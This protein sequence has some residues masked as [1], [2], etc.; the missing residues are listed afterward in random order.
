MSRLFEATVRLAYTQKHLQPFLLPLLAREER[1]RAKKA[2]RTPRW[3]SDMLEMTA[4]T[5]GLEPR[6]TKVTR[7][8]AKFYQ[9]YTELVDDM[10]ERWCDKFGLDPD[11]C[12][13]LADDDGYY[14]IALTMMGHGRTITDGDFDHVASR[15]QLNQLV[16]MIDRKMRDGASAWENI[17]MDAAYDTAGD[18]DEELR[19]VAASQR[20]LRQ[21]R[22]RQ[23]RR[24]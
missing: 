7:D 21:S 14:L 12:D 4:E 16:K 17:L 22:R 23:R 19:D 18:G 2:G 5:V 13:E 1:R 24:A 3:L 11:A 15:G 20:R 8:L 10:V 9:K 6:D